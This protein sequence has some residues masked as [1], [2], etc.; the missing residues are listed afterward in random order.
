[1]S[2][3]TH[4]CGRC[5]CWESNSLHGEKSGWRGSKELE[6]VAGVG[7]CELWGRNWTL[8]MREGKWHRAANINLQMSSFNY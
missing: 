7:G 8:E 1:M 6:R 5:R 4:V 3:E 2:I